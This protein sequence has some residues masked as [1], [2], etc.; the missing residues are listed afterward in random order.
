MWTVGSKF[1]RRWGQLDG[2]QQETMKE[3]KPMNLGKANELSA[4]E[5]AVAEMEA[6][7]VIKKKEGYQDTLPTAA[8]TIVQ[9]DIDLDNIPGEF[10]PNKPISKCPDKVVLSPD[11]YGQRKFD[12]HCNFF[13]KG[14]TVEKIY[15]RRMEDRTEAL[16]NIPIFKEMLAKIPKGSFV[17][18]EI[19]YTEFASGKQK[20]RFVATVVSRKDEESALEAYNE[21]SKTG[22]YEAIP[23]DI[24]F[25]K[26]KF[27][28]GSDYI[29]RHDLL[30]SIGVNPPPIYRD[31]KRYEEAAKAQDWEGFVLRQPGKSSHISYSMDGEAHRAGS[32]KYKFLRTDD[33]FVTDW[34]KGISGKHAKFYAKFRVAQY[35]ESGKI[36][37]RGYV[38]PG[39]LTHE[40]LEQLTVDL[41]S[42]KVQ[43]NFVVEAEYQAIQDSGKLQFGIIQ[44]IRTDKVHTECVAE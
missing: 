6:K 3:C 2:K 42:G 27:V 14:H 26:F 11:T 25:N 39:T 16:K 35:D 24:L 19:I 1:Y 7:I 23:F 36:I 13:V 17:M 32:Y 43:K 29:L 4:A 22:T 40:E 38:G 5:Q 34:I 30:K 20:P 41:D 31:W 33:F 21:L 37:D 28:G 8:S 15:S 12:G 18:C 9:T 10:C 44:R